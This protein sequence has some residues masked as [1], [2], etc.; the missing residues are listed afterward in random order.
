MSSSEN[1]WEITIPP[2]LLLSWTFPPIDL[3][4]PTLQQ[5]M[6]VTLP[7]PSIWT[8]YVL[9]TQDVTAKR[10]LNHR[11]SLKILILG[12]LAST[13]AHS[14]GYFVFPDSRLARFLLTTLAFVCSSS[15]LAA[16]LHIYKK[17]AK[18]VTSDLDAANH[19]LTHASPLIT[20]SLR[21]HDSSHPYATR[22]YI[23]LSVSSSSSP[24]SS[25]P[26]SAPAS[27]SSS[28]YSTTP[29][30]NYHAKDKHLPPKYDDIV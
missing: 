20:A 3:S 11:R 14:L 19:L 4:A 9:A 8:S 1:S 23:L 2:N 25:T 6:Q 22:R 16:F 17:T 10:T 29:A 24:F 30:P 27:A 5:T 13:A 21:S 12:I 28:A 18:E 26:P 15:S 7:D